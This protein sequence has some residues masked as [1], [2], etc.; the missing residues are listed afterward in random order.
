MR[1]AL[2][3][4]ETSFSRGFHGNPL[5][6]LL[7]AADETKPDIL[8]GPEFLFY[9]PWRGHKDSTPYSEYKK[10]KLCKELAAKTG[11]ML[12]IPGTFIW[13]RGLFVFNSAPVIF[14]GKVQHEYFK[15][16][17]GGSGVIAENHSLHYAPGAEEGLVFQWKGLSIGLEICADHHFGILGSRG[18]KTGLHLIASCGGRIKEINSTARE[19]G[20]AAI[21]NGIRIGANMAKRKITGRLYEWPGEHIKN[22]DVYE[23]EL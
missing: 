17:D 6:E 16:E 19:G 5:E 13:K 18:V 11:G 23:L 22:A 9:N 14:D 10:R 8:V 1:L 20:Y 3:R 12:L 15:H 2:I 4:V 7:R 21:C